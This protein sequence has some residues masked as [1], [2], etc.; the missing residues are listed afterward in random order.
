MTKH[1]KDASQRPGATGATPGRLATRISLPALLALTLGM[2][3]AMAAEPVTFVLQ[4]SGFDAGVVANADGR[5]IQAWPGRPQQLTPHRWVAVDVDTHRSVWFDDAGHVSMRGPYVE[6]HDG[7]FARHPEDPDQTALFSAWSEAGTGLLRADGSTFI[8]W[9]PGQGEWAVTPDPQ[10]YRWRSREAGERIFDER[11][12]LRMQLGPNEIRAAG[13][14]PGRAQYLICDLS[15]RAPCALRDEVGRTLWAARLDDLLPLDNGGWLGQQGSVWRRLD[16][17]G[18]L[19]A[20]GSRIYAAAESTGHWPRWVTEYRIE[21]EDEQELVV[22]EDSATG[23]LM[24]ADGRFVAVAGA[25]AGKEVCPGVWRFAM[26]EAGDRL[27]D[28]GGR[29]L[30]PFTAYSWTALD[31]HPTLRLAVAENGE[32]TLV[33]C[34]GK[35]QVHTPPLLRLSAEG[36]GFVGT[37]ADESQPRLWLDA[38]LRQHLLPKGNVIDSVSRDGALLVVR[39]EADGLR[40]YHVKHGRFVGSA[41][42]SVGTLQ[43]SGVVFLRDGYYGFMDADGNERLPPRYTAITPWGNDRLWSSRYADEISATSQVAT[44]HRMDGSA[45]ASWRDATVNDSSMLRN[46]ADQGPVTELIGRTIETAQ[47]SYLGQQWVDRNGRTLFLA[48]HC[49]HRSRETEGAVIEPL[50]GPPRRQGAQCVLPVDVRAA[51]KATVT[52]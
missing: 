21:R 13:P 46:L 38:D 34:T 5:L 37:L 10:R 23:G 25:T 20:E 4:A 16:A 39:S 15:T 1:H 40:L 50:T 30:G 26:G 19:A 8:D 29:V 44:L 45:V 6:I 47:G 12:Q 35:R 52:P 28:A 22:R 17:H 33:D 31:G 14:F 11:G 7:A 3:P 32:E 36:A 49:E 18:H 24:Q 27:G 43:P 2:S 9:Q 42:E 51:M 41:F 48:M